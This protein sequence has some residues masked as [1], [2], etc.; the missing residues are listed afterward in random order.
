MGHVSGFIDFQRKSYTYLP[1]KERLQ[2]YKE[3]TVQQP[4][5][6]LAKQGARCMDCGVPYCHAMGCPVYNLIP[7]WNDLV[8]RGDWKEALVR[9]EMTNNLPEMT[10]RVCPAPCETSCTLSINSSP[11][12]I[13]QVELAIV[14]RGFAE[15][16]VIP[17][18]P[19]TLTGKRVAVV[20]SGPA[21]L[22]A[23]QQLRRAGHEVTVF[24]RSP[25]VG[26]LLRYGI[27]DFK[28]EKRVID[29][30]LAQM[31]AEGVRFQ[32]NVTIGEDISARYLRANFDVILLA[33]GAGEPRDLPVPGRDLGGVHF[34]LDYLTLSNQL[35]NGEIDASRII[36]AKDKVVLVIGG[37]DTGSDCVG[38]ANR[39]GATKVHQFEILPKPPEWKESTNPSWPLWPNILRTSSSHEEG[40]ERDWSITTQRFLG[41]DGSVQ[42]GTFNRVEW[43]RQP[44]GQM[45]MVDAPGTEF[46]LKVDLVLLAMGFV[47]VRHGKILEE[48]GVEYDPRG[49]IRCNPDYS[50]SAPGVFAAGDAHTGASL[51]VRAIY[52][53][54]ESAK[55]VDRY[56]RG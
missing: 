47:H 8:Y 20:G 31:E 34:A 6:E 50:T 5:E 39:Q 46:S 4:E 19:T 44:N 30:R 1:V 56:L 12:T 53:G 54:R 29:R 25:R 18:P 52:H 49:N 36:S 43:K 38:T 14:E 55:A 45:K 40:C 27:P 37:G 10:G 7:E 26:G 23:A 3:F 33:M 32:T 22:S 35:Q 17:R 28:L 21:G 13:K 11:V 24:E 42:G 15:G 2:N 41:E 16:W 9:L 48:L 51:V